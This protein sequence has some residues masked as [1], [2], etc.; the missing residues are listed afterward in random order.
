MSE[1]ELTKAISKLSRTA[2]KHEELTLK[3]ERSFNLTI[4]ELNLIECIRAAMEGNEGPTV[5]TIAANLDITRPSATVAIN[6][7][8][9]KK[10]VEKSGCSNDGRSVRVKLTA[11]GEKVY[12]IHKGYQDNLRKELVGEFGG[13]FD[14]VLDSICKLVEYLENKCEELE[15]EEDDI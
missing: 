11:K 8:L 7:L 9:A 13:E 4:N 6:K 5:S 3:A 10:Y 14:T 12:N 1:K 15:A 2:V